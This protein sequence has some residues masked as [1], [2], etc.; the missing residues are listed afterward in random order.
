MTDPE[1]WLTTA[2]IAKRL[3]LTERTIR[4]WLRSGRLPGIRLGS[5]RAGWRIREAD[6]DAFLAQRSTVQKEST[7]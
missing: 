6:L 7:R 2:E 1:R 5:S 3:S 4:D